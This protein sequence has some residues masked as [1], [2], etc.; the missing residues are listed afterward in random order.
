M[1]VAG[2]PLMGCAVSVAPTGTPSHPKTRGGAPVCELSRDSAQVLHAQ[3]R[4]QQVR[5]HLWSV[6]RLQHARVLT[7]PALHLRV[8]PLR[9]QA[10]QVH[11]L[12][13]LMRRPEGSKALSFASVNLPRLLE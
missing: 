7:Q 13:Q 5:P 6:C 9:T 12:P 3:T 2:V 1:R 4:A 10:R 11:S 8:L